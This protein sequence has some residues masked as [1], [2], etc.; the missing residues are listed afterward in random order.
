M[1]KRVMVVLPFYGGSLPVGRYCV[2]ALR[3]TGCLVDV[4]EAPSFY[5]S[6]KALK[7]LGVRQERLDYLESGYLR[8]VGEAIIAQAER[9][10]PDLLLSMAQAPVGIPVLKRLKNDNVATAMWF[11]EDYRLFTYWRAFAP[12]YD[13]FAVIQREPFLQE[14]AASGV[15]N[16]LYLPMAAQPSVHKALE[17]S[18]AEQKRF[19]SDLSF[20]G[21]GYPNRRQAFRKL[22]DY[23][24]KIWGTEWEGEPALAPFLQLQGQRISSEDT[25][26]IFNASK[27][28]L[29]LHSSTRR[30]QAVT[31]GDFVNP[32]TF[33]IA[34]CG[35]F[36]LVDRRA[37]MGELFAEDE[38][39]V[40]DSMEELLLKTEHYLK[41]PEERLA[42]ARR[43]QAR[44]LKDH[45]YAARMRTL[46]DF[47]SER[48]PGW[49]PSR[50]G[51]MEA[52]LEGLPE[53]LKPQ[54]AALLQELELPPATDF[55][56][57]IAALRSRS[58]RLTHIE[59]ALLFLDEWQKQ[60][61]GVKR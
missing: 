13:V 8:V 5:P 36:Q 48:I 7:K 43:G 44:V 20:M 21:A 35:A 25:V 40:F 26:R 3:E 12:H 10:Q 30:E 29:N 6:F 39:A 16:A 50:E 59:S 18:P 37:L 54:L 38:L 49:P 56:T 27:I 31:H 17:L 32:R 4:F 47:V 60:Y 1:M 2:E 33:E 11:V 55:D 45:T 52:Q 41:N 42:V 57:V 14:L 46:L 23:D 61:A 19:G 34:A 28:N 22:T 53:E 9:F 51:Q 15:P 58:G 24:F